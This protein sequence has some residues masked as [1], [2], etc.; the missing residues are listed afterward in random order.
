MKFD[1]GIDI[2][3]TFTDLCAISE[4]G[5]LITAKS[6]T[7]YLTAW[8][9]PH[10]LSEHYR[11]ADSESPTDALFRPSQA[12]RGLAPECPPKRS[13]DAVQSG[14]HARNRCQGIGEGL[15]PCL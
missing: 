11:R 5:S 12:L 3:G 15:R 13:C 1:V 10:R 4:S 8:E 7:T 9:A 2:G 6:P 14:P